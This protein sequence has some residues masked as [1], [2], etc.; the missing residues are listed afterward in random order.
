MPFPRALRLPRGQ[1]LTTPRPKITRRTYASD[2][3]APPSGGGG[4]NTI[5]IIGAALGIPAAF[6]LFM[7]RGDTHPTPSEKDKPATRKAP[8]GEGS[9]SSKQ[10]G[11]SNADTSNPY[12]NEPGKS[13][14]GEGETE[15]AKFKGTVS[16]QRPQ[17]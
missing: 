11:L 10:E 17:N 15:T 3:S 5:M 9:M 4:N 1:A 2:P 16:P 12:V 13:I 7:G 6:Y 8:A 14:T